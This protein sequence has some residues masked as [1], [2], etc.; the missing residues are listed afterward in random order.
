MNVSR[1]KKSIIQAVSILSITTLLFGCS[2]PNEGADNKKDNNTLTLAWPRD[3]GE[4]NPHVYNPSQLFAQSMV[5]EPL[6]HYAEGGKLEP[7]LAKSWDIS[8]D[9]KTYTFKLRDDVKFS[10]GSVFDATIVKKNFDAVLKN[11]ALHSWLGFI[12]KIDKTEVVDKQT[13]RMTLSEAYYPTIQEL[14][15]VRPVRF[16]GEA[17]F[18]KNGDTSKGVEQ[19]VGTGPWVLDEYKAD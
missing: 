3:I 13:F 14:A 19:E 18:P 2:N 1:R 12:S 8:K 5:Y 4:M 16:L 7:F 15:V 6:V 9:G 10:D 11:K 17:G